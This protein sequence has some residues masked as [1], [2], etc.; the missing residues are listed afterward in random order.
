MSTENH[1]NQHGHSIEKETN[2]NNGHLLCRILN[3]N[4]NH[5]PIS[6]NESSSE[7]FFQFDQV[8][9]KMNYKVKKRIEKVPW[10]F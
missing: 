3:M 8:L 7:I 10:D 5:T 4:I 2:T 6:V 1:T 9:S